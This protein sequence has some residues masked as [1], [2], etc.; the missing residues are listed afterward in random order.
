[1]HSDLMQRGMLAAVLTP[2]KFVACRVFGPVM[3]LKEWIQCKAA[4]A[5]VPALDFKTITL[6]LLEVSWAFTCFTLYVL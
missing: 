5:D 2:R 4:S 6:Q 1:M 3:T